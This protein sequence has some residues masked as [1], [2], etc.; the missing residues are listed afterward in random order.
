MKIYTPVNS[1]T[2]KSGCCKTCNFHTILDILQG[3]PSHWSGNMGSCLLYSEL[4]SSFH[5]LNPFQ[6]FRQ[7]YNH[8]LCVCC[9]VQTT[10]V[11]IMLKKSFYPRVCIHSF[12]M[13]I[14]FF[15]I[16]CDS[17]RFWPS[18]CR[19]LFFNPFN[20]MWFLNLKMLTRFREKL[21]KTLEKTSK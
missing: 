16:G 6:V 20:I 9:T 12:F 2:E 10:S 13:R 3:K 7:I 1:L 14:T 8:S 17:Y 19:V 5:F 11:P 18:F 4:L 15:Q 21:E